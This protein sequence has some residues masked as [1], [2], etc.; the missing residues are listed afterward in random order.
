[1][2]LRLTPAVRSLTLAGCVLALLPTVVSAAPFPV[3]I[4]DPYAGQISPTSSNGDVIG[5]TGGF[6]IESVTISDIATR[7]VTVHVEFNYNFGEATLSPYRIFGVTMEVGDLL[8]SVNGAYKYGVALVD[9][10]GLEAGDLYS[11]TG[12]RDS[13]S[14][15]GGSRLI[16]RYLTAVRM[17]PAGAS[18][19]GDGDVT[20]T[21][22]GGSELDAAITFR[23]GGELLVDLETLGLG[24]HFASAVC[25]NDVIDGRIDP[26]RVP[27]P[28]SFALLAGGLLVLAVARR[29]RRREV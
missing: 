14:Y 23:P 2:P 25:A 10:D 5:T 21:P 9:H 15:L 24:V 7:E 3:V 26:T 18:H 28:P 6:D 13:N 19:L 20:V 16:W 17:N 22:I 29:S 12:T 1:M 27:V 8:F 4:T 11:I